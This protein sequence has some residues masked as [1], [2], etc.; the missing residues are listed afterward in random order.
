MSTLVGL[1]LCW[2]KL[3]IV[4]KCIPTAILNIIS[5]FQI[6]FFLL[7]DG[8]LIGSLQVR[9]DLL[10]LHVRVDR[11]VMSMKEY[12]TFLRALQQEPDNYIYIYI[13]ISQIIIYLYIIIRLIYIYIYHQV[14]LIARNP[15][16]LSRHRSLS[17]I[18][19]SR[20]S[21]LYPVSV[22]SWC[23]SLMVGQ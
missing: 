22:Q 9:V 16:K 17:S 6:D 21:R 7:I 14:V 15:R 3:H 5:L 23:E 8:T 18:G 19:P 2:N 13:Y 10:S 4:Q 20:S 11:E 12:S 1:F